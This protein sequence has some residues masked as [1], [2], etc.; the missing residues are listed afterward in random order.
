[1]APKKGGAKKKKAP[2]I[3]EPPH[4]PTWERVRTCVNVVGTASTRALLL[5][6]S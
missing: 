5:C 1:M 3:Q 6:T 4:D 2:E